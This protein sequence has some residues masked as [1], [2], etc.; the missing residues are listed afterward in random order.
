MSFLGNRAVGHSPCFKPGNNGFH[1]FHFF[2]RH[3]FFRVLEIHQPT[4][5]FNGSFI[6]HQCGVLLKHPI[7][8]PLRRLLQQMDSGRIIQMLIRSAAH[9]VMPQAVQGQIRLQPQRVKGFGMQLI[10][11][12][13]NVL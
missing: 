6:I 1:T 8:A 12:F 13:F 7:V 10:H 11:L 2:Q 4:Q 3:A 5:I 9:L